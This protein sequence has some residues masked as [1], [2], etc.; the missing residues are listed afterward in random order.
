LTHYRSWSGLCGRPLAIAT[1]W[2]G[3]VRPNGDTRIN[4]TWAVSGESLTLIDPV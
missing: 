1:F 3:E 2:L 4:A